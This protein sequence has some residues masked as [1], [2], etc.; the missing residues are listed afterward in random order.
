MNHWKQLWH[1]TKHHCNNHSNR[2]QASN[3]EAS[4]DENELQKNFSVPL[5]QLQSNGCLSRFWFN[6]RHVNSFLSNICQ[7]G[8]RKYTDPMPNHHHQTQTRHGTA[9]S[10]WQIW[11]VFVVQTTLC[12]CFCTKYAPHRPKAKTTNWNWNETKTEEKVAVL[13]QGGYF[14]RFRNWEDFGPTNT[15]G[16]C[17]CCINYLFLYKIYRT[18]E[19]KGKE[20]ET[21]TE[22]QTETETGRPITRDTAALTVAE[23]VVEYVLIMEYFGWLCDW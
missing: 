5:F 18:T 14:W 23:L 22:T 13:S 4:S 7:Y 15:Y 17:F 19:S 16:I 20:E 21:E 6:H 2:R 9:R 3:K 8:K 11:Y 10:R 12:P 1:I